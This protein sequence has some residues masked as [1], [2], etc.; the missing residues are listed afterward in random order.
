MSKQMSLN[1]NRGTWGGRRTKCGRKRIHSRGVSHRTRESV[2]SKRPLHVNFK[3]R[4]SIRNKEVLKIL[5]RALINS[6]AKGLRILHYSV[7]S[8]HMHFILEADNN[9]I[10]ETGMRSLTVTIAK[11]INKGKVQLERYH[12]HVLKTI[13][14]T[15]N[16]ISY[17]LFNEQKHSGKKCIELDGYSSL[18]SLDARA[19]ARKAKLTL[20]I[21]RTKTDIINI[22]EG[23]SFLANTALD[24]LIS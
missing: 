24:Q 17:V 19:L 10:L 22:T 14:E 23:R 1:L 9:K 13:R 6:G 7:Q 18:H 15:K 8:N 4:V 11:G 2:N 20:V 5:K 21:S 12:L 3:Y 16:A